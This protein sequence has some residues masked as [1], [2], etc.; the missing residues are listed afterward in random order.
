MMEPM[1]RLCP[2]AVCLGLSLP[3]VAHAQAPR[4]A[5]VAATRQPIQRELHPPRLDIFEMSP[6]VSWGGGVGAAAG[7]AYGVAFE[8]GRLK[9]LQAAADMVMGFAGGLV[10]GTAVYITKKTVSN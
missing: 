8:R 1:R 9:G 10:A 4:I 7:L 2:I 5:P 3:N 6:Y